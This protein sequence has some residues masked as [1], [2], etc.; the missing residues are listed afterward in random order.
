LKTG[1][2]FAYFPHDLVGYHN[3]IHG[4]QVE[5]AAR[6]CLANLTDK[7]LF[8]EE[9]KKEIALAARWHDAGHIG[10]LRKNALKNAKN[11]KVDAIV[12][13]YTCMCQLTHDA[14]ME[15]PDTIMPTCESCAMED[16]HLAMAHKGLGRPSKPD[17]V[18][19]KFIKYTCAMCC[20][21]DGCTTAFGPA[22]TAAEKITTSGRYDKDDVLKLIAFMSDLSNTLPN[23][24]RDDLKWNQALVD[25]EGKP[26]PKEGEDAMKFL[27]GIW[28]QILPAANHLFDSNFV[29][30]HISTPLTIVK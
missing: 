25:T 21:G 3:D 28:N 16:F 12:N 9:E 23:K 10:D 7:T 14:M 1:D 19:D 30:Q 13:Q 18:F 20:G 6:M 5:N 27:H 29:Q 4:I 26:P 15:A 22:I 24:E 11:F 8:N 2:T 17:S